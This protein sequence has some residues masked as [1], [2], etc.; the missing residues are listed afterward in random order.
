MINETYPQ[1]MSCVDKLISQIIK[2]IK[3]DE[4]KYVDAHPDH[5]HTIPRE[6][7]LRDILMFFNH[8]LN[9]SFPYKK[10]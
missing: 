10:V 5:L 9:N 7:G 6:L 4:Q 2:E 8:D 3:V 1:N